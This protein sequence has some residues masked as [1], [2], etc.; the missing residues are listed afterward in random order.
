MRTLS[1]L[2]DE[3]VYHHL[4]IRI[5][6]T[7]TTKFDG[8]IGA[9]LRNNLLYATEQVSL[10]NGDVSFRQFLNKIPLQEGHPIYKELENGFPA[11]Y[12]LY[13]HNNYEFRNN[14]LI[15]QGEIVSFSLVLIGSRMAE[16]FTLFIDSIRAMCHRG[17]GVNKQPFALIDV[18]ECSH[19]GE[20]KIIATAETNLVSQLS[21]AFSFSLFEKQYATS[22]VNE[23]GIYLS[24][25]LSLS[26]PSTLLIN[27]ENT[28]PNF[29]Q[30]L[31]SATNRFIKLNT[32]YAFP[33]DDERYR[34]LCNSIEKYIN[35]SPLPVLEKATIR[36]I[37]MRGNQRKDNGKCILFEGYVG[38]LLFQGNCTP[39]LSL[40]AFMEHLGIGHNLTY[41]LGKYTMCQYKKETTYDRKNILIGRI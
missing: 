18:C 29:Q 37:N 41:G 6:A 31:R 33:H 34:I 17:L 16:Y 12:Y 26:K 9:V 25:P 40:V 36:R 32:L 20:S 39:Y 2:Q 3:L 8:W 19:R 22:R 10:P 23:I 15:A 13:P 1:L 28:L 14:V 11:P 7:D 30:L 5:A 4:A 24:T 38:D 27:R 35:N 21:H